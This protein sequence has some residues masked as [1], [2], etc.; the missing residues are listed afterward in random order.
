MAPVDK[1]DAASPRKAEQ[2]HHWL[3]EN[4]QAIEA[5]NACVA[6]HGL[7]SDHAGLLGEPR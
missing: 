2:A 4:R 7:L 6:K 1:R 5:Y 3:E